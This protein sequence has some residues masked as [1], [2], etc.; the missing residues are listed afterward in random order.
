MFEEVEKF[1]RRHKKKIIFISATVAAIGIGLNIY[2]EWKRESEKED[3]NSIYSEDQAFNEI[4]PELQALYQK[5][6][7]K[8]YLNLDNLI[9]K[10]LT[11][12]YSISFIFFVCKIQI[13]ILNQ[14]LF[15]KGKNLN[16]SE[17]KAFIKSYFNHFKETIQISF[18]NL[19]KKYS[20]EE[21]ENENVESRIL[22]IRSKLE[23]EIELSFP[24][25]NENSSNL[26]EL[27]QSLSQCFQE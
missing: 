4:I 27:N 26:S 9:E 2:S 25:N 21:F 15:L 20:C 11:V 14:Y 5:E 7:D 19:I 24:K 17:Q 12:I 3:E 8:I 13:N 16:K 22:N 10:S 1:V 18:T 23:E 6:E